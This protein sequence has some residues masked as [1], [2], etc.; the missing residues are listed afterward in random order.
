M[1][2]NIAHMSESQFAFVDVRDNLVTRDI[3]PEHLYIHS[4]EGNKFKIGDQ[5]LNASEDFI[6]SF[7]RLY[8][9]TKRVQSRMI[10]G[11]KGIYKDVISCMNN[12]YNGE[13]AKPTVI[14]EP[15]HK[16]IIDVTWK[17][18][19]KRITNQKLYR[20][21][22]NVMR[23]YPQFVPQH[24]S[25]TDTRLIINLVALSNVQFPDGMYRASGISLI[26]S[27]TT[28]YASQ[29]FTD[30]NSN[31]FIPFGANCISQGTNGDDFELE[32]NSFAQTLI[33][34]KYAPLSSGYKQ[35]IQDLHF[36]NPN[37]YTVEKLFK[38]FKSQLKKSNADSS[39]IEYVGNKYLPEMKRIQTANSKLESDIFKKKSKDK[40]NIAVSK[41]TALALIKRAM[42]AIFD[43]NVK[44]YDNVKFIEEVSSLIDKKSY[45]KEF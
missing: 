3:K 29:F 15:H 13:D 11:D 26:N 44:L 16:R 35:I 38:I 43:D 14:G 17:G 42:G 8:G 12:I 28:T 22:R 21:A 37:V 45:Y 7:G 20:I 25:I 36:N 4:I 39:V 34:N 33:N 24:V 2:T 19:F 27:T 32:V 40:R 10:K 18:Y 1:A 30:H 5:V 41:T 6:Y 9:L 23:K 31:W